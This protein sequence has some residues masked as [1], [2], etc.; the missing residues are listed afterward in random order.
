MYNQIEESPFKTDK[1]EYP[2]FFKKPWAKSVIINLTIPKSYTIESVPKS[3]EYFFPNGM[4]TYT[5]SIV[6]QG[7]IIKINTTFL[8]NSPVIGVEHYQNLKEFY[9]KV[10]A[11]QS[12]KIVL[13]N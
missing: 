8:I 2:A 4:G 9:K 12:E 13:K 5:Y 10:I 3:V 6:P 1:R 7:Q 11:K